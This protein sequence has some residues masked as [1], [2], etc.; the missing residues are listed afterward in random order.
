MKKLLK[1]TLSGVL[2]T[3]LVGGGFLLSEYSYFGL[4]TAVMLTCSIELYRMLTPKRFTA[5]KTCVFAAAFAFFLAA[6]GCFRFGLDPKWLMVSFLPLLAAY[7]VMMFDCC[8]DYCFDTSIFF[9]LLYVMLPVASSLFL[10]FPKGGGYDPWLI[11]SLVILI[12]SN[13][14]GA[15]CLGMGFGQ[16][17]HSAKLFP[18]LSPKKSWIGVAGGTIATFAVA[19]L[20]YSLY[21]AAYMQLGHWM[22]VAAIVSTVGVCGDLFES[23]IKRHSQVKDAGNIIPGHG[24]ALDRFDDVL[25]LLPTVTIYLKLFSLI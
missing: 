17:E 19:W 15:Y 21:G 2:F 6:F 5:E 18:A 4:M 25:F 8:G 20:I 10:V 11:L 22:A 7:I 16:R 24:G 9:P 13:D 1:R 23:L 14:V 3:V 12:W